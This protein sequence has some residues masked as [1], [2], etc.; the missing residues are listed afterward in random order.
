MLK[1]KTDNWQIVT[2]P[3]QD[4]RLKCTSTQ[5]NPIESLKI[6]EKIMEQIR[7]MSKSTMQCYSLV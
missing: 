5:P 6:S 3:W 1:E 4:W 2:H 7:N